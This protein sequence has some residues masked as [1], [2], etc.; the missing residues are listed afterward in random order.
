MKVGAHVSIAGSLDKAVDRAAYLGLDCA[1][2]HGQS[3]R[4]WRKSE[5][6][7]EEIKAFKKKKKEKGISPVF[8]HG[9]YLLNLASPDK[10]LVRKSVDS[11]VHFMELAF[12]IEA[13]GVIFHPGSGKKT[14][15]HDPRVQTSEVVKEVLDK[16]PT[17]PFLILENAVPNGNR[18]GDLAD[19]GF[20][21]RKVKSERLKICLDTCHLFATGYGLRGSSLKETKRE[22]EQEFGLDK[23]VA[24][25]INDSKG[26]FG[27]LIDHHANLGEGEIGV[28]TLREFARDP[29]FYHLPFILETPG[30][31]E[32]APGKDNVRILKSFKK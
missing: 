10:K 17:G 29:D 23:V 19:L 26:E 5:F 25:H 32:E 31:G 30:F 11:L 15:K 6:S 16:S 24:V 13:A 28:E 2:I 12:R 1:Q 18:I 20:V 21:L 14:K 9:I 3:P 4:T 8:I 7:K 27:S 22:A